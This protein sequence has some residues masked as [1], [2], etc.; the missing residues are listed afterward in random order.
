VTVV[1]PPVSQPLAAQR[2]LIVGGAGFIGSH[3]CDRLL[4]PQGGAAGVTLYDNFS[5]GREWHFAPHAGDARLRVVR[6]DAEDTAAMAAA[7][8]GHDVVIRASRRSTSG[9]G[10]R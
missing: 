6:G 4:A 1:S 3:F 8:A 2:F 10:P 9:R 5:S 7:M